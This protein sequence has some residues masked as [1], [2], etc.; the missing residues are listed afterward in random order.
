MC[1]YT[2][3]FPDLL[4]LLTCFLHFSLTFSVVYKH[5]SAQNLQ[6]KCRHYGTLHFSSTLV[7][8]TLNKL[9]LFLKQ[10]SEL[11]LMFNC[12]LISPLLFNIIALRV[13]ESGPKV[14][15]PEF[16]S[17]L[18]TDY[19]GPINFCFSSLKWRK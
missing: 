18:A 15:W 19:L 2:D 17:G 5:F 6:V 4:L 16:K 14:S 8:F 1:F 12:L 9:S 7:S 11:L 3:G 13:A 10:K